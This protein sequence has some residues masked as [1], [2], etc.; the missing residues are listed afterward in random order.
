M[1][2]P[3]PVLPDEERSHRNISGTHQIGMERVMAVLT[4]KQAVLCSG[5]FALQVCPHIGT[6]F[7]GVVGIHL[8]GH[9]PVQE[10]FVGD[11]ALQFGKRPF[12]VGRI[13]FPLLFACFFAVLASGVAL[14][15]LSDL[16]SRSGCVGC[17]LTMRLETT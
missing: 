7:A 3:H 4:D 12:G 9:L 13:G 6:G 1:P 15:C 2:R 14:E 5:R 8:H 11:H 17:V 16:P 10:G